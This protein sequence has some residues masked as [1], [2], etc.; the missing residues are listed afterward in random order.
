MLSAY[1]IL[2]RP[3]KKISLLI[4][5][6]LVVVAS[7]ITGWYFYNFNKYAPT[8]YVT[9]TVS[10]STTTNTVTG[11]RSTTTP[12][13]TLATVTA[14][15]NA[16]SC[17]TIISG[18]VYDVTMWVN[19]H[20]GGKAAILSLCGIDGTIKFMDQHHGGSR[21]MTILARYKIGT[22]N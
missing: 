19:M 1:S 22:V 17:Y 20:P 10:G 6:V 16:S 8:I 2:T 4:A 3:M 5:G 18:S 9:D 14:H 13:Y 21:F 11:E 7:L 15:N 12:K